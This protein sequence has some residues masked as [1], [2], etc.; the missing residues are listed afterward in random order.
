M[1]N[2]Q[3]NELDAAPSIDPASDLVI[4]QKAN[5]GTYKITIDELVNASSKVSSS[6]QLGAPEIISAILPASGNRT[7]TR[8]NLFATN[9]SGI[10]TIKGSGGT[11]GFNREVTGLDINIVKMSG[12]NSVVINGDTI[13]S[14]GAP[15]ININY[16]SLRGYVAPKTW[17]KLFNSGTL[18]ITKD[19]LILKS[20]SIHSAML[21]QTGNPIA[22]ITGQ[23]SISS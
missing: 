20:S 12:L 5:G 21:L 15:A 9:S 22:T 18:K 8:T 17:G 1:A 6:T 10:I 4:I 3:I 2:K 16:S 19:S 14:V 7:I 11:A 23:M 13:L